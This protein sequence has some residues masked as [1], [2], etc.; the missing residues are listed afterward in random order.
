MIP[1][2]LSTWQ[3]L[4]NDMPR[5]LSCDSSQNYC[6]CVK[7]FR[8]RLVYALSV[9]TSSLAQIFRIIWLCVTCFIQPVEHISNI[10]EA[11]GGLYYLAPLGALAGPRTSRYLLGM[12]SV[13]VQDMT[14]I[15]CFGLRAILCVTITLA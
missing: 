11:C 3:I 10:P 6:I 8:A 7:R 14:Y 13:L 9:S 1:Q 12:L 15:A 5:C 2:S 4:I